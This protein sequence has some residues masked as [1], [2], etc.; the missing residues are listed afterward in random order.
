MHYAIPLISAYTKF[1]IFKTCKLIF[2]FINRNKLVECQN[3]E[4]VRLCNENGYKKIFFL[5]R[6]RFGFVID[7][8]F[9]LICCCFLLCFWLFVAFYCS[10]SNDI[11]D[12]HLL[13]FYAQT[14]SDPNLSHECSA[15]FL[16]LC[17]KKHIK[18]FF[19]VRETSVL[20]F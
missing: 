8:L 1:K 13:W 6:F 14:Q 17:K 11:N 4:F 3:G 12:L 2:T 15:S 19:T 9:F 7:V 20:I 5:Y 16:F 10:Y 18:A